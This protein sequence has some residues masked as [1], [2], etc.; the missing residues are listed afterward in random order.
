MPPETPGCIQR[1]ALTSCSTCWHCFVIFTIQNMRMHKRGA[2]I[3]EREARQTQQPQSH[4]KIEPR[5]VACHRPFGTAANYGITQLIGHR[6]PG[7][8]VVHREFVVII[9]VG[10]EGVASPVRRAFDVPNC[11]PRWQRIRMLPA[12][13]LW[14]RCLPG[15]RGRHWP[16]A[17]FPCVLMPRR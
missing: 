15:E 4:N 13:R 17:L 2:E 7:R 5:G 10:V 14:W 11:L 16:P 1:F 12:S 9:L 8:S 6:Q 3:R